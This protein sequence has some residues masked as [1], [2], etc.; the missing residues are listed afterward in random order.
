VDQRG[1]QVA[2][3]LRVALSVA[4]ALLQFAHF[5]GGVQLIARHRTGPEQERS[6]SHWPYRNTL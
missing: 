5:Q 1:R 3:W 2:A 4:L 6:R